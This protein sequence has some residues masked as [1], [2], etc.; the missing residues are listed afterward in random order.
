MH[1]TQSTSGEGGVSIAFIQAIAFLVRSVYSNFDLAL[2]LDV[3]GD[4]ELSIHAQ[5]LPLKPVHTLRRETK[6]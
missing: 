6:T 5:P 4:A 2:E 1:R 3:V